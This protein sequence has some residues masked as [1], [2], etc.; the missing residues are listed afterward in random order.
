M[1]GRDRCYGEGKPAVK[2]RDQHAS[3][4][5]P[6]LGQGPCREQAKPTVRGEG[7]PAGRLNPPPRKTIN[8]RF[9]GFSKRKKDKNAH[10]STIF[11]KKQII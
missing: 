7:Q 10:E 8:S 3:I 2:A 9:F 1:A 5:N 6:R 4:L 11:L